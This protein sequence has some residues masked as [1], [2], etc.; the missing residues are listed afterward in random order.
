[1][2]SLRQARSHLIS[3]NINKKQKASVSLHFCSDELRLFCYVL[4]SGL[5]RAFCF[6]VVILGLQSID[7]FHQ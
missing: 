7:G 2:N 4:L 6:H 1:M 3:A 5:K